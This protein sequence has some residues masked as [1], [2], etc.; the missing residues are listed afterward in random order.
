MS[1]LEELRE[2]ATELDIPGRSGM[3]KAELEEAIAEAKSLLGDQGTEVAEEDAAALEESSD[4]VAAEAGVED[5]GDFGTPV[6]GVG[7]RR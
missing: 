6:R 1:T 5:Q 3:N 7:F 2:E 4:D